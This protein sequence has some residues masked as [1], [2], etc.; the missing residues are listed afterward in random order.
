MIQ[1][2]RDA[3]G[4]IVNYRA[5]ALDALSP[6]PALTIFRAVQEG[7]TNVQKHAHASRVDVTIER[8]DT[9]IRLSLADNGAGN[10][11]ARAEAGFGLLGLRE[12]V[13]FLGGKLSHGARAGGGFELMVELPVGVEGKQKWMKSACSSLT[14][15]R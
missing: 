2:F 1:E 8:D 15:R 3:T 9:A 11:D 10:A 14:T 12:R 4:I 7:L 13:E 6:A 5:P